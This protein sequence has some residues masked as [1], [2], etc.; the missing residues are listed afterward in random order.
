[1][2]TKKDILSTIEMIEQQHLY[3]AYIFKDTNIYKI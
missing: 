2:I 3:L 1:M